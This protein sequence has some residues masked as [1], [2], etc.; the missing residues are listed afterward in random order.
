M[1]KEQMK[2]IIVFDARSG[3]T[4]LSKILTEN[5][6][7]AILPETNFIFQLL[8]N[9]NF[10]KEETLKKIYSERKFKDLRIKKFELKKIIYDNY[11][12]YEKIINEIVCL[13]NIRIYG[14]KSKIGLKK[15][16]IDFTKNLINIFKKKLRVIFLIRDPRNVLVSKLNANKIRP[17]YKKSTIINIYQWIKIHEYLKV[18]KI[19]FLYVKYEDLDQ[20]GLIKIQKYLNLKKM[21]KKKFFLPEDQKKIHPNLDRSFIKN[22]SNY[23]HRI[24]IFD[25]IIINLMCYNYLKKFN[26]TNNNSV[27]YY[28]S[29]QVTS[30]LIRCYVKLKPY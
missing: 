16:Q 7:T 21:K 14:C 9:K 17:R 3:S 26:Y 4:K 5:Y 10:S 15:N 22:I 25:K 13:S 11:R 1:H 20:N 6:N 18:H 29:S 2:F 8:S 19:R 12:N 27:F 28:I 30:F 24:K 23:S